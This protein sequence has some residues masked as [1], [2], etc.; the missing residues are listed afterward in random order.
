V[1]IGR[2]VRHPRIPIAEHTELSHTESRTS[3][4]HLLGSD[5]A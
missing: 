4:R 2:R 5:L 1:L 3:V